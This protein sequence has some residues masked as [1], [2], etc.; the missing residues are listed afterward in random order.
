MVLSYQHNRRQE[1]SYFHS[2]YGGREAPTK[3]PNLE[4]QFDLNTFDADIQYEHLSADNHKTTVG[5]QHNYQNNTIG[6]Y[7]FLLPK[8]KVFDMME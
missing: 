6:G 5:V 4:L 3:N 2:H 1:S 8:Y 7:G